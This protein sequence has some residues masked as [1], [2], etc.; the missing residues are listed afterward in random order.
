MGGH[1]PCLKVENREGASQHK[2][3]DFI[4]RDIGLSLAPVF[5]VSHYPGFK[6]ARTY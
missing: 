1:L 6:L 3:L 4:K 2:Y 5:L